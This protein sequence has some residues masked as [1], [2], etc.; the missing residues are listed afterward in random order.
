[1]F[2][3]TFPRHDENVTF[4]KDVNNKR[5]IHHEMHESKEKL[6]PFIYIA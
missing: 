3:E 2:A 5:E 4:N 6:F 1:V